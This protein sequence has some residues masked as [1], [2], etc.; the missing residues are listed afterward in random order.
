MC[1]TKNYKYW[2]PDSKKV[3]GGG[4]LVAK[5]CQ[6]LCNP[7]DCSPP[8]FSVHRIFQARILERVALPFSRESSQ[9]KDQ[10]HV[11]CTVDSLLTEPPGKPNRYAF[12]HIEIDNM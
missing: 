9:P 7:M 5:S 6:S 4:G 10:T 8:S 1:E 3:F 12:I 2:K 11:S